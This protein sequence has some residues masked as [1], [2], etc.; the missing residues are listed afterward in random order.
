[1]VN[2]Q[3][4]TTN[5]CSVDTLQLRLIKQQL[6]KMDFLDHISLIFF[7]EYKLLKLFNLKRSSLLSV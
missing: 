4:K 7:Q 2:R 1:M 6:I 3:C 5:C